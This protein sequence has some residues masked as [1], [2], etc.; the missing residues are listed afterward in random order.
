MGKN[1]NKNDI[2]NYFRGKEYFSINDIHDYFGRNKE[3]IKRA[4]VNW[5]VYELVQQGILQR[6]SRG[7]YTLGKQKSFIIHTSNKQ[8]KISSSIKKHF[9]LITYCCWHSSVLVE[10]YQHINTNDFF[11]V[12]VEKEVVS[13]VYNFLKETNQN[14]FNNPS[15]EIVE[16]FIMGVKNAIVIKPLITEAPIRISKKI[17]VPSLEKIIV[18]LLADNELFYFLQ[19]NEL[20]NIIRNTTDKYAIQKAKLLRYAKRRNKKEEILEI[21]NQ[22]N[23]KISLFF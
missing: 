14:V 23:S 8:T 4:T 18:D 7:V 9:P 20:V 15:Q 6:V 11:I 19:G 1:A 16:D 21:L 3:E 17:P 10:F 5:R 22:A 2:I 13:S 12:E